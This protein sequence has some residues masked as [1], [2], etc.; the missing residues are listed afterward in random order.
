MQEDEYVELLVGSGYGTFI[1][2]HF[3]EFFADVAMGVDGKYFEVL[4]EGPNHH[5][6]WDSWQKVLDEAHF[7][8]RDGNK[9]E[10]YQDG[11]LWAFSLEKMSELNK[12]FPFA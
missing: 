4:L 6:Y 7:K 9:W 1:P 12:V 5:L 3:A 11:D 2:Q 10:L 8:D